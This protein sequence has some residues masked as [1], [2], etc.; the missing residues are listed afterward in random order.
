MDWWEGAWTGKL[1]GRRGPHEPG[2]ARQE[3]VCGVGRPQGSMVR[4]PAKGL[5]ASLHVAG[6][7]APTAWD[8]ITA[9]T[10]EVIRGETLEG[11]YGW[12]TKPRGTVF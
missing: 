5:A 12:S 1:W 9:S 11:S 6:V 8:R 2:A 3:R 10:D 7:A 4:R